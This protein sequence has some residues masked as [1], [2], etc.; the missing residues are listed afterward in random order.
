VE[1]AV[2][3]PLIDPQTGEDLG[4]PLLGVLD[5]V[6][7]YEAGPLICDFK[8]SGRSS[9]PIE[10]L[11]EIQ[12][13]SYAYLFRQVSQ[14]PESGLEI[15]SLIKTKTPKVEFH[16]YPAR[17][18]VHFRRLFA[19]L[20]EYLDALDSGRSVMTI[21]DER[22]V[23]KSTWLA[24]ETVQFLP[25]LEIPEAGRL[26]VT[27]GEAEFTRPLAVRLGIPQCRS[28]VFPSALA[29]E[30]HHPQDDTR[31]PFPPS[32]WPESSAPRVPQ[33]WRWP[34]DGV[35][36]AA[37]RPLE[38]SLRSSNRYPGACGCSGQFHAG[39]PLAVLVDPL[40]RKVRLPRLFSSRSAI[41][42][43]LT[44]Q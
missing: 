2:E 22:H 19:V 3:A 7:D 35:D 10:I 27:G 1:A 4:I 8:T 11:H 36:T 15:R 32:L 41:L 5:L 21:L 12:L 33:Q 38:L 17:T 20:H 28:C 43:L 18:E 31:R 44:A 26:V 14:W 37:L 29:T 40:D 16:S 23:V 39:P 34:R 6:L 9:E 30:S 25:G 42:G 24:V 13:S